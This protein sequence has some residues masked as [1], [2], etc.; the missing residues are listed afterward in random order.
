MA[1]RLLTKSDIASVLSMSDC[2]DAVEAAFVA[3]ARGDTIAPGVLATHVTG[4]GF[5]VKTAGMTTSR[6]YY[7]AKVNANFPD[8]PRLR[9]LPTVQG[10]LLL[11]DAVNGMLLAVMDSAEITRLRTAAAS[12]VAARHM[13][14]ANA[15]VMTVCG[16]GLQGRAHVDAIMAVRPIERIFAWDA[17]R[18]SADAFAGE[19]SRQRQVKVIRVDSH[20]EGTLQSDIV[21]TTTASREAFLR[22]ADLRPG[23]FVAA[24]GADSDTKRELATDVLTGATVVADI[25]EQCATIGD[26]HHAIA[27]G[28]MQAADI[29]GELADV[30]SGRVPGRRSE[31]EITIFDSTGT[32]LEDVAAAAWAYER[33]TAV[34]EIEL[35]S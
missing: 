34:A 5:H 8:N 29:H 32:A 14:R 15:T 25:R 16:C 35:S 9:H 4:G 23:T 10:A 21:V 27:E 2:I 6:S 3:H 18:D 11:Y 17:H 26:L 30:V 22:L 1:T 13:A 12:A 19:I 24:V 31:E 20:S 7:V 33:A 28:R